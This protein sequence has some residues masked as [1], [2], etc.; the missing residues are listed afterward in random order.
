MRRI[1]RGPWPTGED[2]EPLSFDPYTKARIPLIK[3]VGEYCSYC[4][5]EGDL[6]VEHVIPKSI[7]PN[8]ET[9]W[10][11]FLLGC[12]NCNSTKLN[13]NKSRNGF[14]WPDQDDTFNAFTYRSGGRISVADG[15]APDVECRAKALF[16]LVG[17]GAKETDSNRRRH[18]RRHAWEKATVQR[19]RI[20]DT[21]TREM[22]IDVALGTGF[23]SV[24]MAVFRD[25]EDM[26]RR[27]KQAFPGTR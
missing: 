21:N 23:Y 10:S 4:E 17:L 26:C 22:A 15:L 20:K 14:L 1:C 12:V 6:H 25:D 5:R 18:K 19:G 2:G 9:N 3:K 7:A 27:L 24:W 13:N 11:N 16:D 8:L